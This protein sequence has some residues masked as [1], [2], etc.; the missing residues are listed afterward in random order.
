MNRG[1]LA[2]TV[3]AEGPGVLYLGCFVA[4]AGIW[5]ILGLNI[6]WLNTN[7]PRYGKR[8][9]ASGMQIML[10]NIP[11]VISPWLYTNNDAPLYTKGHA[12]NL[13]LVAFAG[14]VHAVMCFYFTWENKQ[15]SMGRRDHR[16]E[17]KTEKEILEM[18][19][20]SP[21]FQFTR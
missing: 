3:T 5:V 15:R 10:G 14:V 9:T 12:V 8:A 21:R 16:I 7:N 18:A 6:A 20:E 19:D 1:L 13:A 2:S 17:G 11:G 4:A